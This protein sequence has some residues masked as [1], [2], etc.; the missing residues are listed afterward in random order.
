MNVRLTKEQ[1]AQMLLLTYMGVVE[2]EELE[3]DHQAQLVA[4]MVAAIDYMEQQG[5]V[6]VPASMI[7]ANQP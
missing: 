6:I 1:Y 2:F 4:Q 5:H 7:A 3:P